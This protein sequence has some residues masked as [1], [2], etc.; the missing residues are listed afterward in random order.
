MRRNSF[1]LSLLGCL[2][3]CVGTDTG[4][5]TRGGSGSEFERPRVSGCKSHGG[6][7]ST[8]LAA[9]ALTTSNA[10]DYD[11]LQCLRWEREGNRVRFEAFN[12]TDSC[13]VSFVGRVDAPRPGHVNVVLK[14]PACEIA[15][16]GSC[17][18]DAAVEIDTV[19]AKLADDA[20]VE[21][22]TE[23][24][25]GIQT[26]L[27]SWQLAPGDG[28]SALQCSYPR[29]ADLIDHARRQNLC[30]KREMPCRTSCGSKDVACDPGLVCGAAGEYSSTCLAE[31]QSDGDCHLPEVMT[32]QQG[33]CRLRN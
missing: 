3:A 5:P 7:L 12:F 13:E 32:C 6:Q 21:L 31:C 1:A 28:A 14:N 22:R 20:E 15:G 33:V 10:H 18:Y 2:A 9:Q 29:G 30:G 23:D 25:K 4:N 8:G 24:C 17:M 11:G 27:A 19:R 26:R 16:C